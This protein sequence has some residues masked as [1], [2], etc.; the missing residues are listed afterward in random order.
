VRSLD[1]MT[2]LVALLLLATADPAARERAGRAAALVS[3]VAGDY[4]AAVGPRGEILSPPE[5]AEQYQFVRQ[6][7]EE[8]RAL[9]A[10]D[11]ARELDA[12]GGRVEARAPP[13]EVTAEAQR[14]AARIAQRFELALLPR[15]QPDLRRGQRLYR[16][17]CAACHGAGGTPPA[18]ERLALPTRPVAFSSKPEVSRLSPQRVFA[19]ATYG[20]PGTA[21]PSFGEALTENE[22][23]DLSFYALTLAHAVPG[24]RARGE[25][26]LRKAPGSPDYLQLAVRSDDQLR[27]ALSRSGLS[28]QDREAVLSAVR[29]AFPT[30]S[31][32]ASR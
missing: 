11:L 19:A 15:S 29:T 16:Q 9:A 3:Y 22:R 32:R 14:I 26:L 6:A 23:W 31:R 28:P 21:M 7:A 18:P 10:E 30:T 17:A 20:V 27:A 2:G 24:E 1:R 25:E 8:L 5:L 12:L 4:A 13:P